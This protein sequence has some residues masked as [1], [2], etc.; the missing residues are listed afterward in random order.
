MGN[1]NLR[2]IKF[3]Q[4]LTDFPLTVSLGSEN[5]SWGL[6][7]WG[8]RE[9]LRFVPPDDEGFT[10]RGSKKRLVYKGRKR[11]HR[12]TILSDCFFEY[13]C[14]LLREPESNVVSLRIEGAEN[15]DFFLQPDFV[16]DP[17][18]K[19]SYAVYKKETLLGEGTGKLCHIHRPEIIDAR[20]RRCWGDL[21]IVKNHLC[22]TI[23][24][25]WLADAA[26]PVIVDPTV[27]TTTIGS[28]I[29]GPDPNNKNYDRPMLD[30]EYTV[31]KYLVPQNGSGLCTAFIYCYYHDS[32]S[33][34][35]PFLYT[36]VNNKP[37]KLKS[38]NE[39]HIYVWVNTPTW[40]NNTFTIDGIISAGEHIWFGI[41]SSWFTT[42]F[43]YAGECYKG[44]FGYGD[45]DYDGE[46]LPLYLNMS[47][48][49]SFSTIRWS[50]YFTYTAVTSQN[51]VR[52]LTQGVKITDSRT[53][54][55]DYKRCATQT[56]KAIENC[57]AIKTIYRKM[58]ELVQGLD[59]YYFPV[60]FLRSMP[61]SAKVSDSL[62]F[63]RGFSR[64][65]FDTVE[66]ASETKPGKIFF[67]RLS[68]TIKV[69]GIV[70]RGL[71][72]FVRITTGLF[73][74]DYIINRFLKAKSDLVLKSCICREVIL[75]SRIY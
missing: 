25:Q 45:D 40:R 7:R 62:G 70:F 66:A 17:F 65:L 50:M 71:V 28:Q 49:D 44:W 72:F 10:L 61:E 74:R 57:N 20:G 67:I 68:E 31:N 32:D 59:A 35:L 23:P 60:V 26:Y 18:L 69:L 27:G 47:P 5:P 41:H 12:F 43:D 48:N 11:S 13:D 1:N 54:R 22:I 14:I 4:S 75:E 8:G 19:G 52:T 73:V 33:Y 30:N 29:T 63:L 56:V 9:G 2:A 42:R 51:F 58:Q 15:F 24:E 36:N 16:P 6:S 64:G 39:N 53:L 34:A 37:H 3:R 21:S 55:L 38:K 46:S